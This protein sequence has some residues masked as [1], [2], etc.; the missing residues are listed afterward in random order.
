VRPRAY[1]PAVRASSCVERLARAMSEAAHAAG[2]PFDRT[3]SAALRGASHRAGYVAALSDTRD[4]WARAYHG[5]PRTRG[6]VAAGEL[7]A[8]LLDAGEDVGVGA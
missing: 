3:W 4:A 7:V 5:E 2:V 8:W 6:E 1:L